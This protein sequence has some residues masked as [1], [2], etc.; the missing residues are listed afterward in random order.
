MHAFTTVALLHALWPH[1]LA[2][3]PPHAVGA[4]GLLLQ[5]PNP[6][7]N[8]VTIVKPWV[9]GAIILG[10]LSLG[11]GFGLKF[12]MPEASML[13]MN[14]LKGIGVAMFIVGLALTPASLAA[15]ASVFGAGSLTYCA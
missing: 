8:L 1:L 5:I 12:I 7:C 9:G 10:L 14:G 3:S 11:I 4:A 6:F 15:I 2:S 13:L